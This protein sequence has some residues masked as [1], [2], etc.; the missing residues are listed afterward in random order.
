MTPPA[1]TCAAVTNGNGGVV[2]SL[3]EHE[4]DGSVRLMDHIVIPIST[5]PDLVEQL[6]QLMTSHGLLQSRAAMH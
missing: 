5:I 6:Q 4:A 1:F 3:A 2:L